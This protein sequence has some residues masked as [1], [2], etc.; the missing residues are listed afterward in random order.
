M[1][2]SIRQTID[3]AVDQALAHAK[4]H[5]IPAGAICATRNDEIT[6]EFLRA[7]DQ[8]AVVLTAKG[9]EERPLDQVF[10]AN[11]AKRLALAASTTVIGE[12]PEDCGTFVINL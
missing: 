1:N 3:Q 12:P 10:D 6:F 4:T 9:E 7:K 8:I 11:L 5:G 2:Q